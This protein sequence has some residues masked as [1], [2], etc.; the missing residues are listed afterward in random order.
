M[1]N[2]APTVGVVTFVYSDWIQQYPEFAATVTQ[3]VAQNFFNRLTI[4]GPIDNTPDSPIQ[5]VDELT[6]LLYLGV[7]HVAA[8]AGAL[9]ASRLGTVGRVS[10][11]TEGSVNVTLEYVAP[12]G[13]L[14]AWWQQTSYGAQYYAST[15]KYRT[16]FYAPA[17]IRRRNRFGCIGRWD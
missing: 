5:N 9:D 17:P 12:K 4:G 15:L 11:A 10:A 14:A 1:V 6:I 13:T 7:A 16:A 3:T 2:T 8:L